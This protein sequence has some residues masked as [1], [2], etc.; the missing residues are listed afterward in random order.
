MF[1]FNSHEGGLTGR[2]LKPS[3]DEASPLMQEKQSLFVTLS[4]GEEHPRLIGGLMFMLVVLL[5]IGVGFWF[6]KPAES[7]K[8]PAPMV[9]EV[10]LLSTPAQKAEVTPPAPPKPPEPLKPEPP[11]KQPA[12]QPV[13]KKTPVI[14]KQAE[15]PK[16]QPVIA[17]EK[18]APSDSAPVSP[19]PAPAPQPP[20]SRP[21]PAVISNE[22]KISTGVVPLERVPPKYPA[23][24]AN[25]HIEGWVKIEFT[26]T[27][28]GTVENAVV[29]EAEPAEV[30]DEAALKAINQWIFKEKIVNGVAVEQRAVQTL[31]FK[32]TQ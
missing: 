13:K 23:R 31:Q 29:V 15:L 3:N 2:N 14:P 6:L 16:P 12:K 22:P 4:G 7:P 19:V 27:T 32:L 17:E 11:K 1:L 21:A 5:H 20:V 24:A 10:S 26:I 28:S 9:M 18:P 25:R 8:P 30:F